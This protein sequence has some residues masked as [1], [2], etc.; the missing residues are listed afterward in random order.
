VIRILSFVLISF[1]IPGWLF[2]QTP[3]QIEQ[4]KKVYA[5]NKCQI[6]HSVADQGNKKG[7]LDGVGKKLSADE[8]REWMV[9]APAMTAKTKSERKPMMK[10][11]PNIAKE[12]LDA[13][14]AYMRS[15]K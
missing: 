4:G 12:D 14:V 3:A 5:A 7:P 8:I 9:D 1:V 2:A 13:L 15:L 10:S 6:C 11:Y